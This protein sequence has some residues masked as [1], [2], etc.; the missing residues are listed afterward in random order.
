MTET[1]TVRCATHPDVETNL[2]C[3]KCGKPICPRCLVQTPVG[4]RCRDCARLYKLPTYRVSGVFYARAAGTAF[5]MGI[6]TGLAWGFINDF[7]PFFYLNL[8][9]AGGIGY[10][11]GEVV[12]LS[13]NRKRGRWLAATGGAAV[14]VSYLVSIFTFG[15]IP[16]SAFW[17]VFD[18]VSIGVGI[19]TAVNRLR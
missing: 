10:A 2:R 12:S 8:L 13:I 18:I 11:I 7:I 4:A 17:I 16:S 15:G 6:L 9:L 5:G 19:Y 14:V 1:Q 3:G